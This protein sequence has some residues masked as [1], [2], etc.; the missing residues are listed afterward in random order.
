MPFAPVVPFWV[1]G[2]GFRLVV[3]LPSLLS[4]LQLAMDSQLFDT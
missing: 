4:T 2:D 3:I 1:M